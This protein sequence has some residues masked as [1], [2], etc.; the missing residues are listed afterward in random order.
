MLKSPFTRV[1]TALLLEK[2]GWKNIEK[3]IDKVQDHAPNNYN[4]LP[5]RDNDSQPPA[6]MRM[7][8]TP[9]NYKDLPI[10][11][12]ETIEQPKPLA[13]EP[14]IEPLKGFWLQFID[15]FNPNIL[16]ETA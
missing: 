9:N 7:N 10:Q 8:H 12:T 11:K 15:T 3:N 16:N 1:L 14:Q 5:M 13:E 6:S 4:D 2:A